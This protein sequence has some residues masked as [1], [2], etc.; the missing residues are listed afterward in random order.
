MKILVTGG[1]GFIGSHVLDAFV[2]EGFDVVTV[3]NLSS[4][5]HKNITPAVSFY[6]VDIRE[7]SLETVFALERP[8]IVNHHAAQ[9]SVPSSVR[10]PLHDADVNVRGL[11]NTLECCTKYG[12]KKMI[13]ISSGGAVYGETDELPIPEDFRPDPV[14]PYAINKFV[15]EYYLKFYKREHGL[16]YTVLRYSNIYG[17]RQ[18]PQGE[19]GVVALFIEKFLRGELP[20]LYRYPEAPEGMTRD[21]CY[22]EDVARANLLA[23]DRGNGEIL[24]L[25][26]G[27][28]TSTRTL[29]EM[30]LSL[31]REQGYAR[32]PRFENPHKDTAVISGA[33]PSTLRRRKQ[34]CNGDRSTT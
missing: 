15:S 23:L 24:N 20:T 34:Y 18:V 29:Y 6:P 16:D 7:K 11:L 21:Y 2:R 28:E 22:V 12:A 25:G 33:V 17:P 5:A 4:G 30:I 8:D 9:I 14:S 27:I 10:D 1:A 13:F 26:T 3:D 32:D 31:V 19:A